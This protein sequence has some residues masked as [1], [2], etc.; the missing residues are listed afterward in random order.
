MESVLVAAPNGVY[1]L[2]FNPDDPQTR[3]DPAAAPSA[4]L[5]QGSRRGMGGHDGDGGS[6]EQRSCV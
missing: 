2:P 5:P 3:P 4:M 6:G 1:Y